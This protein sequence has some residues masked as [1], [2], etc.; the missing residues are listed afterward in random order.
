MYGDVR[1]TIGYDFTN[2][3]WVYNQSYCQQI[4]RLPQLE[5][6]WVIETSYFR[7]SHVTFVSVPQSFDSYVSPLFSVTMSF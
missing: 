1:F 3:L 2:Q 6:D 7:D 5:S 4:L